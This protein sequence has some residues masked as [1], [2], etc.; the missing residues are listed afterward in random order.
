[1]VSSSRKKILT[2]FPKREELSLRTVH[3]FPKVSRIGLQ[4]RTYFST[5]NLTASSVDGL[6]RL[7]SIFMASF[8]F[9]VLPAPLS[10]LMKMA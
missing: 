7:V 8:A 5:E 10:P 2:N 6:L 4:A 9:S 1:M 3:A